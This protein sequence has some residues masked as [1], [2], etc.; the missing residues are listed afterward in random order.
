VSPAPRPDHRGIAA[1]GSAPVQEPVRVRAPRGARRRPP[2]APA[3][4]RPVRPGGGWSR[5]ARRL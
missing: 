5:A 4:T 1:P 3:H 2:R